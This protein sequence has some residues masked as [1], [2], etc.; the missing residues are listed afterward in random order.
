MRRLDI[1]DPVLSYVTTLL[2]CMLD[3]RVFFSLVA[4]YR[5]T[6]VYRVEACRVGTNYFT[7]SLFYYW[8]LYILHTLC[9]SFAGQRN[10]TRP[11]APQNSEYVT[12]ESARSGG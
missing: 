12:G 11:S 1:A 8:L 3:E 5:Q 6:A 10:P 7:F 4:Q 2:Q 9:I